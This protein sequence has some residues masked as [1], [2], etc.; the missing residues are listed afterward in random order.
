MALSSWGGSTGKGGGGGGSYYLSFFPRDDNYYTLFRIFTH[1][2][3]SGS[4]ECEKN[5]MAI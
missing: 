2:T 3:N 1:Y 5:D 4:A